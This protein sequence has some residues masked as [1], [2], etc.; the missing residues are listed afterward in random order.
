MRIKVYLTL[1]LFGCVQQLLMA[2]NN[3]YKFSHL[4]VT[5]GLSDDHNNCIFKDHKGYMW[6]GT[7]SGGL[8][9]YDGYKFKTFKHDAKDTSSL[10]ENYVMHIN[11]GP[12][13]KLWIFT[14]SGLSVF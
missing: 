8:S 6:F 3:Q 7:I 4:D 1:L 14:R 13:N 10:A 11:E 12:E 2:Q 5:N 9:R